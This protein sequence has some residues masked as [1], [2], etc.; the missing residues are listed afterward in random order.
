MVPYCRAEPVLHHMSKVVEEMRA[1]LH[2]KW[3]ITHAA[4]E[5]EECGCG[6]E[7]LLGEWTGMQ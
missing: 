4:L 1:Y 5:A 3:G 2:E 6:R 7:E